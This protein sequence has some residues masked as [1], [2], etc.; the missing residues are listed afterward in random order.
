[1]KIFADLHHT[2]LYASFHYLFE[3]R[4]GHELYRPIGHDWF[5]QG[6]WKIAAPYGDN[7]ATIDQYLKINS[8]PKD[9]TPQLNQT[10]KIEEDIHYIWDGHRDFH[11]KAITLD[12]FLSMDFDVIIASIPDHI[13][14]YKKLIKD[15]NLKAKLIYHIGNIGWHDHIPWT[16]VDN[17]MA[18]VKEF[19]TL[20][21]KNVVFYRQEFDLDLF[22]PVN[23]TKNQITSFV[24][25]LPNAFT[26]DTMAAKMPEYEWKAYGISSPDGIISDIRQLA[27]IMRESKFGYHYK[28]QGD[29]YGHII[30]NWMAVGRPV[31]VGLYD[32]ADKL[33][34]E[35]LVD[36]ETCINISIRSPGQVAAIVHDITHD[37]RYEIMVENV[38]KKFKE[39]VDFE[40]DAKKV[41]LFLKFLR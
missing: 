11:Q 33:A 9:G 25:I 36:M 20:P 16:E 8:K 34:G 39:M 30:H 15:H 5:K 24:N 26:W 40:K 29:G 6:Y 14:A 2:D 37:G 27:G 32:Y 38:K 22:K 31:L 41:E 21:E 12:K 19:P 23:E 35:M 4:L 3:D 18:S 1:M 10:E 28:P 17:I 7:P 13:E